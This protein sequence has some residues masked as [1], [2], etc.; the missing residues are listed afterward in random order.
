MP[1][2]TTTTVL[3]FGD[4]T[5]EGSVPQ[6]IPLSFSLTYTEQ[7][8]KI[9]HIA[10]SAVDSL[11]TLDSVATPKFLFARSLEGD[12]TIKISDGVVATPTPSALTSTSGWVMIANPS[13]Q[14]I[15]RILVTTPASPTT[16][17]RIQVIAFE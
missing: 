14:V 7:S 13:G 9:V 16:G 12:V 1:T 8:T 11:I 5:P 17:A 3:S 6:R 2:L 15:N 10:A 4:T